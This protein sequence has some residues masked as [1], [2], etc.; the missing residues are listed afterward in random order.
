MN[1]LDL[2]VC[3]LIV[4][5][6]CFQLKQKFKFITG[7]SSGKIPCTAFDYFKTAG[8][9]R[10]SGERGLAV[11]KKLGLVVEAL[12]FL[13]KVLPPTLASEADNTHINYW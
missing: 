9:H 12:P 13:A 7:C 4:K 2:F 11:L 1:I 3:F 10:L 6:S 8:T 5:D